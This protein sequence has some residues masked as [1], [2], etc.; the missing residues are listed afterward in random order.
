MRAHVTMNETKRKAKGV[1]ESHHLQPL[2]DVIPEDCHSFY[3]N[4]P[5]HNN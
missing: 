5:H 4:I 3:D 1:E 2:Q